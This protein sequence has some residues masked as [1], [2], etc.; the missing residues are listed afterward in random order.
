[1]VA[2]IRGAALIKPLLDDMRREHWRSACRTAIGVTE[3]MLGV[4]VVCLN[5]S[6][7]RLREERRRWISDYPKSRST[8]HER[9]FIL[10]AYAMYK[11]PDAPVSD[12]HAQTVG[13]VEACRRRRAFNIEPYSLH[14]L[15]SMV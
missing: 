14:S 1:M 5:L 2:A 3:D 10:E 15:S 13:D 4:F 11:L 9:R 6:E 7:G 12:V 8:D